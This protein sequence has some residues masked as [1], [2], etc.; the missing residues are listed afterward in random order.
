MLHV[1]FFA[2]GFAAVIYQVIWQRALLALYGANV[3][4]VTVV[5]TAF[6]LGLG[7]GSL[8]GG[9]IATRTRADLPTVFGAM[10]LGIGAWGV[11]SLP[12]FQRVGAWTVDAPPMAAGAAIFGLLLVPTILMG[13]TLPILVTHAAREARTV[14][15]AVGGLYASNALGS[16]AGALAAVLVIFGALGQRRSV[17]LAVLINTAVAAAVL[18][19]RRARARVT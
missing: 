3:E 14:G 17:W 4:S 7:T 5:V 12:L 1:V 15:R 16:A 8:L 2:S 13:A 18:S 9:Y 6:M 19:W 10:E 11:V